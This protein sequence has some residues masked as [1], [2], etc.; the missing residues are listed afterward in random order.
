[1]QDRKFFEAKLREYICLRKFVMDNTKEWFASWFDSPF[2]R[3]LYAHRSGEEARA[4]ILSLIE[5]LNMPAYSSV[6]DV[7]CGNGR[8]SAVFSEKSYNVVGIDIS[9]KSLEEAKSRNL[10]NS[11]F[12]NADARNFELRERFDT[13]KQQEAIKRRQ[14]ASNRIHNKPQFLILKNANMGEPW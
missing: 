14:A 6:L 4:F 8:H 10:I 3:E 11:K 2:Y 13:T 7:C 5:K 9:E 12:H 1:V